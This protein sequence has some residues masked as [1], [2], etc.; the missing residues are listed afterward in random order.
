[1][2]TPSPGSYEHAILQDAE[3]PAEWWERGEQR[4]I[5]AINAT[6]KARER[7]LGH[8]GWVPTQVQER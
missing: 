3:E 7:G 2:E 4:V 1:M 6:A 8:R 5:E